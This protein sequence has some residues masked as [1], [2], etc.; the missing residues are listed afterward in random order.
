[1]RI[2]LFLFL[3]F[4][5]KCF[6]QNYKTEGFSSEFN[7]YVTQ[8]ETFLQSSHNK[9]LK[10]IYNEFCN[11]SNKDT[12]SDLE[13]QIIIQ[14]SNKML[15][16]QLRAN[17]YFK[18]FLNTLNKFQGSSKTLKWLQ[19]TLD[20]I[21]SS[22]NK[23]LVTFFRFTDNLISTQTLRKSKS[24]QWLI[25]HQNY[26]FGFRENEPIIEFIEP[27][28]IKCIA[29]GGYFIIGETEGVYYPLNN[30]WHGNGGV[31][32]WQRDRIDRDSIY[33]DL[34]QYNIDARTA[35]IE[36][37]SVK[38][39]NHTLFLNSLYGKLIHKI[40]VGR[41][42]ETYPRFNSYS[43]NV[44]ILDIFPNIDYKGGYKILGNE[45]VADGGK[46]ADASI[47]F[48]NNNKSLFIARANRFSIETDKI[49]SQNAAITIF[50]NEDSIYHSNLQ[51]K[52]LNNERLLQLYRDKST[53]S[54]S[55]MIDTYHQLA[56]DFELLEWS[57]DGD[58]ITFGS[59]PGNSIS[60]VSFESTDLYLEKRFDNL[61]G[62]DEIHPLIL[63]NRYIE[64]KGEK[65]F[66]VVDFAKFIGYPFTQ[67]QHYLMNL[68]NYG[69]LFYDFSEDRVVVQ[70]S[71][72]RYIQANSKESDYDV[73]QFNSII[74]NPDISKVSTNAALNIDT[75]DLMIRGIPNIS[76]SSVQDVVLVPSNGR[77]LVKKNRDFV[78][79]GRVS[80]GNGR[81]NLFG[82]NFY[83]NYDDFKLDLN[84]IDSVQLYAPVKPN[85]KDM[86]GNDILTR[87]NTVIEA[88]T[89]DLKIDHPTNKSGLKKDEFPQYPI[90]RSFED[91]YVYYD[92]QNIFNGIYNREDFVFHLEPFEIDSLEN[93]TGEG[94]SFPGFFVSN[95]FPQLHDTLSLQDD[96]SLGFHHATPVE[97]FHIYN[98]KAKY[99]NDI[100]LS[101]K[102][103]CGSGS[104]Q[105]ITT[106]VFADSILFFPDSVNLIADTFK[107]KPVFS[108][109]E[110]PEVSNTK[111][112]VHYQPYLDRL[113]ARELIEPFSL[114]NK[115]VFLSGDILVQPSGLTGNGL[116]VL[117]KTQLSSNAFT[118]NAIWFGA[119]TTNLEVLAD[120]E[121]V[122][123]RAENLRSH[124]DLNERS[125]VFYSNGDDSFVDLPENQYRCYINT[126][127]WDMI[128]QKL[129]LGDST[130]TKFEFVSTHKD[131]DS[132]SFFAN[133]ANYNFQD[134][135]IKAKG[136]D[137]I[138]VADATI[139]PDSGL[140]IIDKD[141][142]LHP[143]YN[144]KISISSVSDKHIF[145]NSTINIQ[146]ADNYT[147]SG[148]YM[149]A[150]R[151]EE[152]QEVMFN[153]IRVNKE[154][155][156]T[157][158]ASIDTSLAF[159][160]SNEYGFKG[161]INLIGNQDD[162]IFDGYFNIHHQCLFD[163]EWIKFTSSIDPKN[164]VF[165]LDSLI[166]N[167]KKE[168]LSS[169]FF[170]DSDSLEIYSTFFSKKRGRSDKGL[171]IAS[172]ELSYSMDEKR[173][174]V[175]QKASV[176]NY[177]VLDK[178]SCFSE[179]S[180][181]IDLGLN[182]GRLGITTIGT[183]SNPKDANLQTKL[184]G[185]FLLD[186]Y[187]SK[188]AIDI[189][190]NNILEASG[191]EFFVYDS[192]Y[193]R[194]LSI[195]VGQEK[196]ENLL[197][198]LELQDEFEKFPKSL[199][200]TIGFTDIE[201]I[202]DNK[203]KAYIAK[204]KLGLG[205]I[206]DTQINSVFDGYIM[207][208]KGKRKDELII[209]LQTEFYDTYYFHYKNGI[210]RAF[211]TTND[212]FNTVIKDVSENKRR[213]KQE[214]GKKAYR[215]QLATEDAVDKFY[216]LMQKR[217]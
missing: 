23:E 198:D 31:I 210:M 129:R 142:Y 172:E 189:M 3:L 54:G 156:T 46:Y 147:A 15:E 16:K 33:V 182:L 146:G 144:S 117:D 60:N 120:N 53:G 21:G 55:P 106:N 1:M 183:I 36:A 79:S 170:F 59:L 101:Q 63:V 32:N 112:Y 19:A 167:D 70:S 93:Y 92:D 125:G 24:V 103:L 115:T 123:L 108:G 138:Y 128:N 39:Y 85:R 184:E 178:N 28:N 68:A 27:V 81:F 43:K 11:L 26:F 135:L 91:S 192:L 196:A 99:Y 200:K 119:D 44:Q 201:F 83:F 157:A 4:S 72:S 162:L 207:L 97:G 163:K 205:N 87:V 181:R 190:S 20:M 110:F 65:K 75:R 130:D 50:F 212:M 132:L 186:F 152:V 5:F 96:Y 185:F 64:E 160:F 133:E 191:T 67:T 52:Y 22:T 187:F 136:V 149:F 174:L 89:G 35:S 188:D 195:L 71:L 51:F 155:I 166:Y 78:F 150:S 127:S 69:F 37:D 25:S 141:A 95:I 30:K 197:I 57:I 12:F 131:Q 47:V 153:E 56:I 14:I 118:F 134:Y 179:G 73:I 177:F 6:S 107:I 111:S 77:I 215:Y 211:S 158:T 74:Q 17:P 48:K 7:L 193:A 109:V 208:K 175:G 45:F 154:V 58:M 82:H 203:H 49:S 42:S 140:V 161:I 9:E 98:R 94:L 66:Y 116:V 105:Y 121:S 202:W 113:E 148:V 169:G 8:L 29:E 122:G 199:N 80:A 173:Y 62:I 217:Y 41:Q 10:I 159:K 124:I 209:Y 143:L 86:Y 206:Y 90:F 114:Y 213:A 171:L 38:F 164:I 216:N 139:Y 204:G 13:K 137:S 104:L 145:T 40:T 194:N 165:D 61:Q 100:N 34:S 168:V 102:G 151:N 126:L 214:D 84:R 88:V 180:G 76:L 18:N 2:Y 176:D